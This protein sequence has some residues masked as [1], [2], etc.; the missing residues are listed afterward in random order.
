[1]IPP[2]L[3]NSPNALAINELLFDIISIVPGNQESAPIYAF[4][5]PDPLFLERMDATGIYRKVK[6]FF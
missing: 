5:Y 4:D 6:K 2:S 1:M 3:I